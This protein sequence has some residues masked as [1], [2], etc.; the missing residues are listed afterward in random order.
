MLLFPIPEVTLQGDIYVRIPSKFSRNPFLGFFISGEAIPLAGEHF[1]ASPTN[2]DLFCALMLTSSD[3]PDFYVTPPIQ[4]CLAGL[5]FQK[6]Q[7]P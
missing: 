2:F 1:F 7:L 5:I 3:P 6:S 4:W